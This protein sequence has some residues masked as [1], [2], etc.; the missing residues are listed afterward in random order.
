M[1][2]VVQGRTSFKQLRRLHICRQL[3]PAYNCNVAYSCKV[4]LLRTTAKF[5]CLQLR[6]CRQLFPAY[7][8]NVAYNCKVN[9]LRTTA[10]FM[11]F[12]T[13]HL[14]AAVPCVQ[15]QRCVQL[16][17]KLAAY[18]C[19]VHVVCNCTFAGSCSV[20]TTATLRTTAKLT[21]CVQLQTS[22]CLWRAAASAWPAE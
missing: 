10:K 8:C 9:L 4:N 2:K 19:K 14:P 3:F 22:C 11:L 1:R 6:I 13:A 15:L 5:I 16:Q 17:S 18:N 20:R 12:A 21:C 7:H